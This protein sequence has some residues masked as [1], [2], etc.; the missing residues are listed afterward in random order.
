VR[1]RHHNPVLNLAYD[2]KIYDS[3][4]TWEAALSNRV[5]VAELT[6]ARLFANDA[7]PAANSPAAKPPPVLKFDDRD[8]KTPANLLD[9]SPFYNAMLTESWHGNAGNDLSE[10][11]RGLQTTKD[12]QFDIRGIVQLGSKS[13]SAARYP[14]QIKDIPV[15]QKCQRIH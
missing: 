15:H 8:P 2:G 7:P 5:S 9:L 1:C 6:A 11:P 12:A 13:Q 10:L 14:S 3:P 4:S